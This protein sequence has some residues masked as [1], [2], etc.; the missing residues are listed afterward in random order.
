MAARGQSDP[1]GLLVARR[2]GELVGA[3]FIGQLPGG[4][5]VM[6]PPRADHPGIEDALTA[7]ALK[8]VAALKVV[9][10]FL[11]PEEV[12]QAAPLRRAGFQHVT[13]I[14]Q[15]DRPDPNG[16]P[17]R[18]RTGSA[19]DGN[20]GL[21][22]PEL[23]A[24][25]RLG[26]PRID[27]VAHANC[28]PAAF[29][30]ALLRAHGDSLDCPEL[31]EVLSPEDT[32][33]GYLDSSPDTSLWRLAVADGEPAGVLLLNG[34]ELS[35]LGVLPEFRGRGVGQRLL[36]VAVETAPRLSLVVDVR[37]GPAIQLYRS[38]GFGV[39]ATREVFL[40]FPVPPLV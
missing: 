11:P 24:F 31:N 6:W 15:M 21:Q 2:D 28:D 26:S 10:A 39:V 16:E 19:S 29:N 37:N 23:P 14:W 22:G 3:V 5:A 40:H 9:Q 33:A 1:S 4:V 25:T 8:H 36:D 30:T 32:L 20:Y 38:A 7:A 34:D 17:R 13:R 12:R 27:V 18:I 35:F